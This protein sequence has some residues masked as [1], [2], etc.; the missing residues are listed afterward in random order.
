MKKKISLL[1]VALILI[2]FIPQMTAQAKNVTALK[3]NQKFAFTRGVAYGRDD[4]DISSY[5]IE[6]SN[7]VKLRDV[8]AILVGEFYQFNVGYDK[9]RNLVIVEPYI[10]YNKS[11]SDLS[12]ITNNKAKA[13]VSKKPI[14]IN[15]E[16]KLVNMAYINGN[17]Y[18]KLRDIASLIGFPVKYEEQSKTVLLA[19]DTEEGQEAKVIETY[20]LADDM[21][22]DKIKDIFDAFIENNEAKA[23][24]A[25]ESIEGFN[26]DISFEIQRE[27]LYENAEKLGIIPSKNYNKVKKTVIRK[28]SPGGFSYSDEINYEFE[29]DDYTG[30]KLTLYDYGVRDYQLFYINPYRK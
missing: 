19:M 15:G 5:S 24:M 13:T 10:H 28:L 16:E 3:S 27:D 22:I 29:Y 30:I 9:E 14:L 11:E 2:A 18:M 4:I 8:A 1:L 7:Y 12:K 6:G 26:I 17:N 23:E 20:D 21:D 25:G